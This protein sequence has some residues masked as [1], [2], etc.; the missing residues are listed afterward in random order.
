MFIIRTPD[1][2]LHH[3]RCPT[4]A[5]SLCDISHLQIAL[6]SR[7]TKCQALL[8]L[9]GVFIVRHDDLPCWCLQNWQ[10]TFSRDRGI[11]QQSFTCF[12]THVV[13]GNNY[14]IHRRCFFSEEAPPNIP[15]RS[16]KASCTTL[17]SAH[18]YAELWT[19]PLSGTDGLPLRIALHVGDKLHKD[20]PNQINTRA[21]RKFV[22]VSERM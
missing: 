17:A 1:L 4:C 3:I 22:H 8:Q 21:T 15:G 11:G 20:E 19:A 9:R 18:S 10:K 13:Y 5:V 6:L 12:N 14:R 16:M 7:N 2:A